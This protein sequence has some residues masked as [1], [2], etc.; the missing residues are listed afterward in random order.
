MERNFPGGVFPE[1][2]SGDGVFAFDAYSPDNGSDIWVL[3]PDSLE[4]RLLIESPLDEFAGDFSPDGRWLA[5]LVYEAGQME[6]YVTDYPAG[7]KQILLSSNAG[8]GKEPIWSP[9]GDEVFYRSDRHIF[10]VAVE[11][12][13]ELR[14]GTPQ[15]LFEGRFATVSG[16]EFDVGPEAQ[17]FLMLL[18]PP[19]PLATQIRLVTNWFEELNKLA[20]VDEN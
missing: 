17:R 18:E 5:Y 10:S 4:P 19:Q 3:P 2:W 6:V 8:E 16:P 13:S 9:K 1:A 20:P 14:P 11:I 15:S 7:E 12:G